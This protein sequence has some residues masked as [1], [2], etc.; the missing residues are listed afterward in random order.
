MATEFGMYR[1]ELR[2][3]MREA[4]QAQQESMGP[5]SDAV[6]RF[7][8]GDGSMNRRRLFVLGGG[9]LLAAALA[10]CG[11]ADAEP[12]IP[13]GGDAVPTTVTVEP[14]PVDDV[15]LLRTASSIEWLAV[16]GYQSVLDMG[17]LTSP[18]LVDAAELFQRQHRE[19]AVLIEAATTEAGG[20]PFTEPNPNLQTGFV[21]PS[22]ETLTDEIS[23][24]NFALELEDTAGA[25]YQVFVPLFSTRELRQTVQ[26]VG[27]VERRHSVI[28]TA[29]I[30]DEQL[31]P[32]PFGIVTLAVGPASYIPSE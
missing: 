24:V 10:A 19:H 3:Q 23:A 12:Q 5:W 15:T 21:E 4:E 27:G 9:G 31:I 26:S 2:R 13:Q 28:L 25:T 11:G 22:L 6:M 1:D 20:Q 8:S 14:P 30:P 16:D 17:L 18:A 32:S 7:A 29:V